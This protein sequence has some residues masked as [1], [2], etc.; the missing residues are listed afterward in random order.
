MRCYICNSVND[1]HLVTNPGEYTSQGIFR[2][3]L[4]PT[5]FLCY[6]CDVESR[7]CLV[8]LEVGED[9]E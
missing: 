9:D 1:H 4:D 2:D 5:R 6:T 3:P 8:E 7:D